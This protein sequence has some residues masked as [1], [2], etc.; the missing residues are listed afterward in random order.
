MYLS[1]LYNLIFFFTSGKDNFIITA[2]DESYQSICHNK[3]IIYLI[4]WIK[5][6]N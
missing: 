4:R 5:N 1:Y 3:P 6:I 2:Y